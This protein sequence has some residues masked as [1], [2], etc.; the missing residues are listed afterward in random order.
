MDTLLHIE[1][2]RK[3][4]EYM[5]TVS[6]LMG[7]EGFASMSKKY[8]YAQEVCIRSSGKVIH[9]TEMLWPHCRVG[10]ALSGGVDSF[11]LVKVMSIR[12][13]IVPFPFEIMVIHLNPGFDPQNHQHLLDWLTKAGIACHLECTNFGLE[14]H[15]EKN[16]RHSAC[17]RCAWLRRKRLFE[18]CNQYQLTHLAF[19]HNTEDLVSTFFLNLCR[20]GRVEG[21][22]IKESFF[23]G[24]LQIIRP[25]LLTE[26]KY[27]LSAARQWKL[28]VFANP[29]PSSGHTERSSVQEHLDSLYSL[30]HDA[31]RCIKNALTRWQLQCNVG[32]KAMAVR[33]EARSANTVTA[34]T[35]IPTPG[36]GGE[37]D[38]G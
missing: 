3:A 14:A 32:A 29:C 21:M 24:S 13:S 17:F 2:E 33:Q 16:L 6:S 23:R 26:K 10:I 9:Q 28:P 27:I 38:N 8:S 1:Q 7:K 36:L 35:K 30:H 12:Q 11:V 37:E 34:G 25:L 15:S 22:S 20:N 5:P 4:F 19:G 18:L 31:R